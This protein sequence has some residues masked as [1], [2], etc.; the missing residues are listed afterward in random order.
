ME[1]LDSAVP[2]WCLLQLAFVAFLGCGE[3]KPTLDESGDYFIEA[4]TAIADG[5]TAKALELLGKSIESKP[6]G[7]AYFQRAQIYVD[8]GKDA[9]ALADAEEGLKIEPENLDLKWLRDELNKPKPK[10]FQGKFKNPP[11]A[12][13]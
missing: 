8:Q 7:F 2:L 3:S 11:R 1:R 6:Y 4:Q 5:D 13:K 9:E 12:V 10:R